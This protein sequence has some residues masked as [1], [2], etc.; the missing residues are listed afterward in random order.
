MTHI[1]L[2]VMEISISISLLIA[3]LLLLTPFLDRRYAA[4]WKYWIWIFLALR[5]ILP[6]HGAD[7]RAVV[8]AWS[9]KES[10]F[11]RRLGK[12]IRKVFP[13]RPCLRAEL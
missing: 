2:A 5:L 6:F 12:G 9:Q 4:K 1:F 7:V 11:E 8:D 10:R 13:N 3:V